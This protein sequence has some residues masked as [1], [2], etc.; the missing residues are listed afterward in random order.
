MY[1]DIKIGVNF[2]LQGNTTTI[3]HKIVE[4][5]HNYW[6]GDFKSKRKDQHTTAT[7]TT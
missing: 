3:D 5:S 4:T 2:L 7:K 6:L 1:T